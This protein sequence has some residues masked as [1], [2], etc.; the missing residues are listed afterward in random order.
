MPKIPIITAQKLIKVLKKNDFVFVRSKG[1]HHIF[2][3][4]SKKISLSVPIHKSRDLG[5]GITLSILKDAE[6]TTEKFLNDL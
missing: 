4:M 1:S 2:A 5:K 3:N 6:I